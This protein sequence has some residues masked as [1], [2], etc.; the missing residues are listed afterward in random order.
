VSDLVEDRAGIRQLASPQSI[1]QEHALMKHLHPP[2]FISARPLHFAGTLALC[3]VGFAGTA[4]FAQNALPTTGGHYAISENGKQLGEAQFS[5]SPIAGGA[6][7]TSSGQMKLDKF[8]YSF[9][10][11]ATVDAGGNLVRD[12]LT[13]SV[14]GSK[15]SGNNIQ[16]DTASDATGRNFKMT[17]NADGKLTSNTVDRHQNTVLVPDLDPAAYSLMAHLC[18]RKPDTAWVIIPKQDGI[19]VP[20]LYEPE[21]DLQGMMNGQ[22]VTVHH[23]AAALSMQNSIV[24][25]LF[26]EDNG[27]L[28]EA[29]L[30]AQN[31]HVIADGFKLKDHPKPVAPP[32]GEAPQQNGQQPNAQPGQPQQGQQSDGPPPQ[33]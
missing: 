5:V 9:N 30:N 23:V 7:L 11:Q 2:S 32:A 4:A 20:A 26:F 6:T 28:L 15:A 25:E 1:F 16:F 29:D 24:V 21:P 8:S 10:S 13:G 18:L 19:L 14:H 27:T 31:L 17:I 12:Q 33:Q 22:P 3:A